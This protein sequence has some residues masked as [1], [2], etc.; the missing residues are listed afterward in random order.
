MSQPS[1]LKSGL[2]KGS[3]SITSLK[4]G[5]VLVGVAFEDPDEFE[6]LGGRGHDG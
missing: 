1:D 2:M 3:R 6:D 4:S 5:E